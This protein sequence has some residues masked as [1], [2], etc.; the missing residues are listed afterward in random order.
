MKGG[1][2]KLFGRV[3]KVAIIEAFAQNFDFEMSASEIQDI[4]GI[5]KRA[6]YL[7]ISKLVGEGI[8]LEKKNRPK[9]FSLNMNDVRGK[10]LAVM[11]PML[12]MGGLESFMKSEMGIPQSSMLPEGIMENTEYLETGRS[13]YIEIDN[14]NQLLFKTV[15]L[16]ETNTRDANG[17][18]TAYSTPSAA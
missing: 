10:T 8:L 6:T 1:F 11:E 3:P 9:L 15:T 14:T 17:T 16:N 12:E 7:I 13:K 2:T 18:N 5:S 4:S